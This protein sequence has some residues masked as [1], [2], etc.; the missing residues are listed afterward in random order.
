MLSSTANYHHT[1]VGVMSI[2]LLVSAAAICAALGAYTNSI[3]FRVTAVILLIA[4]MFMSSLTVT[5][6]PDAV[7]YSF[8][9]RIY[10][11]QIAMRD[12][13]LAEPAT[14]SVF[15][16]WGIRITGEGMLY[17]ISGRQ[18]VRVRLRT[19]KALRL[20]TDDPAGLTEAIT[21]NIHT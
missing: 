6:S 1:Q 10:S 19:G 16:G 17:N 4:G 13:V 18:A 9:G 20:G 5:V 12:I 14:T 15:D 2:I 21:R 8:G 3:A 11:G 7:T